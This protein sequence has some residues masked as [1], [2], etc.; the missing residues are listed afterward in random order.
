MMLHKNMQH[1]PSNLLSHVS[2]R[3]GKPRRHYPFGDEKATRPPTMMQTCSVPPPRFLLGTSPHGGQSSFFQGV[4][5][6]PVTTTTR[7]NSQ[8]RGAAART[9]THTSRDSVVVSSEDGV[10]SPFA[11]QDTF[12]RQRL[13]HHSNDWTPDAASSRFRHVA[14]HA[15]ETPSLGNASSATPEPEQQRREDDYTDDVPPWVGEEAPTVDIG[16]SNIVASRVRRTRRKLTTVDGTAPSRVQHRQKRRLLSELEVEIVNRK[17]LIDIARLTYLALLDAIL[18][19]V[20]G[21]TA[22][23][24]RARPMVQTILDGRRLADPAR[25]AALVHLLIE[26]SA[27]SIATDMPF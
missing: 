6:G 21:N 23:Y 15:R 12:T 3:Q 2:Q 5:P 16:I 8:C 20:N 11:L 22:W 10:P 27:S 14:Y 7:S 25:T 24:D 19:R 18:G 1:Q 17:L 4:R 26:Q 13:R 9:R